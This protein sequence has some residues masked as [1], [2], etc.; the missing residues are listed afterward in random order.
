MR[1]K[2]NQ[3]K[4]K[5]KLLESQ[6]R[7]FEAS[8][9]YTTDMKNSFDELKRQHTSTM[10]KAN[11][12]KLELQTKLTQQQTNVGYYQIH[13]DALQLIWDEFV[14]VATS[15]GVLFRDSQNAFNVID[16]Q[17]LINSL[18]VFKTNGETLR[19][20]LNETAANLNIDIKL[21]VHI[22]GPIPEGYA[23]AYKNAIDTRTAQ[24]VTYETVS[25]YLNNAL[26]LELNDNTTGD[27]VI[28]QM[29]PKIDVYNASAKLNDKL[30]ALIGWANENSSVK[31]RSD[32]T[33]EQMKR[34]L[35]IMIF[36]NTETTKFDELANNLEMSDLEK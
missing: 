6:L 9:A 34:T 13:F 26:G 11:I 20:I 15:M 22:I 28:E 4:S 30:Q 17:T 23:L 21:D 36:G 5:N 14:K 3:L 18:G 24:A 2:Y 19:G 35:Q 25:K 31:I 7:I 12:E 27:N 10:N 8:E 1:D 33:L 29:K 32:M 16:L